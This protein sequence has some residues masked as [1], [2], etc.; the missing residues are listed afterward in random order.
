MNLEETKQFMIDIAKEAGQMAKEKFGSVKE[1]KRKEEKTQL[2]SEVD[3]AAEN[4]I[5]SRILE[6]FPDHAILAEESADSGEADKDSEYLWIIDPIDGTRNFLHGHPSFGVSIALAKDKE[7]ILGVVHFPIYD[8]VYVA[9]KGKGAEKNGEAITVSDRTPD[10]EE[11][12][13]GN[14]GC[15]FSR[16]KDEQIEV[17]SKL[18]DIVKKVRIEGSATFG[19][20]LVAEGVYDCYIQ[21]F[22]KPWDYAASALI[23]EEAGGKVTDY[24]GKAWGIDMGGKI[25]SSNGKFHDKLI[26]I[27]E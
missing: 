24:E 19:F 21:R 3:F 12:M 5:K 26:E 16:E 7:V 1:Y 11:D 20:C 6:K 23:I 25:I 8:W 22:I 27:S 4:I 17:F 2:V 13:M 14:F 10:S 15:N 18:I 9:E